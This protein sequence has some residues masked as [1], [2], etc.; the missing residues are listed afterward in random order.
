MRRRK[1]ILISILLAIILIGAGGGLWWYRHRAPGM[2]A[3]AEL[4][5]EAAKF[6][7]A[8]DMADRFIAKHPD[9]WQGHYVRAKALVHLKRYA[10]ARA[11]LERAAKLDPNQVS[12]H[13]V[14]AE[15]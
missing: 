9:D 8:L 5:I 10:D 6:R 7:D 15:T 3:T 2:L 13:L 4:A 12:V 11:S 1:V 14:M